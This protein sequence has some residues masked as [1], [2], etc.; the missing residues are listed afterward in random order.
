MGPRRQLLRRDLDP[1]ANGFSFDEPDGATV[2]R[3]DRQIEGETEFV[4]HRGDDVFGEVFV[5]FGLP[6]IGIG[7]TDDG[8][9]GDPSA[10]HDRKTRAG[11]VIPSDRGIDFRSSSEIGHP[12]HEGRV[13]QPLL[14]EIDQE[15]G[16]GLV[17]LRHAVLFQ[18]VEAILVVIP[19]R[20]ADGYE[21]HSG[22]DQ[23]A[24]EEE[25]LSKGAAA[26]IVS[27]CFRFA[28]DIEGLFGFRSGDH[29]ERRL[30]ML[31]EGIVGSGLL[32][33]RT[34]H[35][36]DLCEKFTAA[37]DP[38]QLHIQGWCD[39]ADGE[40]IDVGFR[41]DFKG[42][43]FQS[44]DAGQSSLEGAIDVS[45]QLDEGRECGLEAHLMRH[46]RTYAGIDERGVEVSARHAPVIGDPMP[47][48]LRVPAAQ[49]REAFHFFGHAG[50]QFGEVHTGNGRLDHTQRAANAVRGERLGIEGI[51]VAGSP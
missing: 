16:D 45:A 48:I 3:R 17:D 28:S 19:A 41:V 13:E 35:T 44:K 18:A 30:V 31:V 7:F 2:A 33:R 4:V 8:S 9:A 6:A 29:F 10:G 14:F 40:S 38:R 22:L 20:V 50:A 34:L 12:D 23:S 42:C 51:V 24:G 37:V 26:V 49:K 27:E 43:V 25:S 21:T 47:C 15:C 39:I 32:V 46:N 11:P 5:R 36:I 1:L